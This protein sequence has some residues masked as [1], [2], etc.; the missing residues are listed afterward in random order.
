MRHKSPA[1]TE[2]DAMFGYV[3]EQPTAA[4]LENLINSRFDDLENRLDKIGSNV[5]AVGLCVLAL[6]AALYFKWF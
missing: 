6:W 4:D 2:L 3:E 1:D 5:W